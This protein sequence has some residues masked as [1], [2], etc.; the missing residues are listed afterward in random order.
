[1]IVLHAHPSP[2][3]LGTGQNFGALAFPFPRAPTLSGETYSSAAHLY[4]QHGM[5]FVFNSI[6]L[7]EK[8]QLRIAQT[9]CYCTITVVVKVCVR[10][11]TLT[12]LS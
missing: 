4:L 10:L 6:K 8:W 1:M 3:C 7:R 9:D 2:G 11:S 12:S 5:Q